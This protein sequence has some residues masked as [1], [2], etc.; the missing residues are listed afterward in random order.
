MD[1]ALE[2]VQI[3]DLSRVQAG[4]SCA[5]LLGF[6]GADVIKVEDTDGGDRTRWELA[7][8]EGVDSVYFTIF[9][10]N[11]RAITLNLKT[12]RGIELLTPL[13]KW[14][15][16]VL[17]NYSKGVMDRLGI[18]YSRLKEINPGVIH[19]SIKGFGEWG[20]YSDY[21][22]F[23]TAAQATG[24]LMAAN[25]TP[26]GPPMSSPIGAGDSASGLHMAVG[27]LA[28]LRQ[29]DRTGEGQHVEVSMQDGVVNLMRIRLIRSLSVGGPNRR[30]SS[31]GWS[32]VPSVFKC[33]P[34]GYDDYVMIHM[35]G[36]AWDTVLAII[37]RE[38]LIGD[39]RYATDELR[40]QRADEVEAIVTEWTSTHTKYDAFETLAAAGV[41]SGAVISPEEVLTNEHLL[42]REMI[43]DVEDPVR[44]DYK[45]IGCPVKME[46]SPAK[47]TAAPRYGEHTDEI[48]TG[49]LNVSPDELPELR[50]HGVI[51]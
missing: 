30:S 48:L 41:W 25:G 28:A 33:R 26:D 12:Q 15:D 10:S 45:M 2:G 17:E 21:R 3:L 42:A 38:D 22:S 1:S 36:D 37:G 23:E 19:A 11:K 47:V 39:E 20:P 40:S 14:A 8:R 43:V 31:L 49:V 5:Q 51:V 27:I 9:N 4:P 13:V 32:S 7:H 24:G 29:R 6:L 44:G 50:K 35:R 34:G 18:G 46:R 16:V